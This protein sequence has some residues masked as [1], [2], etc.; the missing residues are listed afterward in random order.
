MTSLKLKQ[1]RH[2]LGMTQR[3]LSQQLGMTVQQISNYENNRSPVPRVVELALMF[4]MGREYY[5]ESAFQKD[6]DRKDMEVY[7][8]M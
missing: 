2:M 3:E 8:A 1:A 6:W 7:D 5:D 4:L